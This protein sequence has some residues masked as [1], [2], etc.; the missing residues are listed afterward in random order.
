MRLFLATLFALA[1]LVSATRA[2][3]K[4]KPAAAPVRFGIA[5]NLEAY[6]QRTAKEAFASVLKAIEA[7]RIDYLLSQLTD[8]V[9]VDE[10]V[11]RLFGG[12]LDQQVAESKAKLDALAVKQLQRFQDKGSWS[13]ANDKAVLRLKDLPERVVKLRRM[14]ARWYLENQNKPDQS[15]K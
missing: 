7:G 8:P 12:K 11:Q 9:F 10:R 4:T 5:A 1:V 6:P 2:D 13:E 14:G 3:D 15:G